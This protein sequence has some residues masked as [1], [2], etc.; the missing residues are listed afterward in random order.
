L[1]KTLFVKVFSNW[2]SIQIPNRKIVVSFQIT[3]YILFLC[4]LVGYAVIFPSPIEAGIHENAGTRAM[5]FL[6]IGVGAEG[7]SMGESQV[8]HT[9]DLYA[10]FWNPAGLAS[11]R[12]SQFAFMH[13]EWFGDINHEYIGFAQPLGDLGA[14]AGSLI[15]LSYGELIGRDENGNETKP[16]H[17]YDLALILS[18]ARKFGSLSVGG[19][20][21]WV[22]EKILSGNEAEQLRSSTEA[23]SAQAAEANALALDIGGLYTFPGSNGEDG[24]FSIGLNLQHLGRTRFIEESFLLP[25]N[26]KVGVAYEM[27]KD[28]A[29]IVADLNRPSDNNIS[30]GIGLAFTALKWFHVRSGYKYIIG[31]NDLGAVSGVTAGLGAS[32]GNFQIDYAF[33]FM[34]QFGPTHRF[35]LL[36]RF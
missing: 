8:A 31:G 19:N 32:A 21:K 28:A 10:T 23:T 24:P 27:L 7:I 13:N 6:K 35:S 30:L 15:Y 2:I 33:I 16:F 1:L 20:I 11:V 18:M 22:R 25:V 4:L 5:T 36:A 9:D 17:P 14:V 3:T 12:Q 34:G 29:V 26:L